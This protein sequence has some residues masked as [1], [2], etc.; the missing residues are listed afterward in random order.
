MHGGAWRIGAK[1]MFTGPTFTRLARQGHLVMDVEYTLAPDTDI[2]G[3]IRDVKRAI[4]W[5]KKNGAIYGVDPARIVL[6]G[7]SAGA[8]LA[9]MA[10]YS[11][12]DPE[13]QPDASKDDTA[14]FGVVSYYGPSDLAAVQAD[15][16]VVGQRLM[17]RK[18]FWPYGLVVESLLKVVGLIPAGLDIEDVEYYMT[19]LVGVDLTSD[20]ARYRRLS[21]VERVGPHCPPTLLLQGEMD[22]FGLA[23]ATRRLHAALQRAGVLSVLVEFPQTDHAFDLVLPWISP[24]AQS[25]IYDLERFLALLLVDSPTISHPFFQPLNEQNGNEKHTQLERSD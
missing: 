18:R 11:P 8:H 5:L 17:R 14:V 3:M 12:N 21:P 19:D 15:V 7:G 24:S 2:S 22:I 13:F 4:L 20:P 9:L 23:P 25:A 16:E 1:N 10:A 6:M